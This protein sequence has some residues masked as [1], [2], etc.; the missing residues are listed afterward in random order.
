M[1]SAGFGGVPVQQV[2]GVEGESLKPVS[3]NFAA[4]PWGLHILSPE[5]VWVAA[6]V[7]RSALVSAGIEAAAAGG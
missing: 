3:A 7:H 4:I 1:Q 2:E 5:V 6:V